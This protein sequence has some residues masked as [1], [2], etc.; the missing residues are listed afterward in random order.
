METDEEM[1]KDMFKGAY[2]VEITKN[3]IVIA[4]YMACFHGY[5]PCRLPTIVIETRGELLKE[6]G[7]PEIYDEANLPYTI[8]EAH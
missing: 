4:K 5:D 2:N 3:G 7:P 8:R 1:L 6:Y